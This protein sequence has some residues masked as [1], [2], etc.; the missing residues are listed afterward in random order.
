MRPWH[1][2]G[3]PEF[4]NDQLE[5][6]PRTEF[7]LRRTA[8]RR[9]LLSA[10]VAVA[11]SGALKGAEKLE[12]IDKAWL[13]ANYTKSEY[14]IPMHNGVKLF[15]AVYAPKDL[16][17]NYPIWITRTPYSVGPMARMLIRIPKTP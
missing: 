1:K 16:D 6:S 2:L 13:E 7:T 17:S 5:I 12:P 3:L 4:Y 14:R 11:L 15:T 9:H 10:V 8:F